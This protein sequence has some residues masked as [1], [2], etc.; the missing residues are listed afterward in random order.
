MSIL[1]YITL[2]LLIKLSIA[3]DPLLG[4]FCTLLSFVEPQFSA[5][6]HVGNNMISLNRGWLKSDFKVVLLPKNTCQWIQ[7]C[8]DSQE[9]L[10][11]CQLNTERLWYDYSEKIVRK[12]PNVQ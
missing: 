5:I 11:I 8:P 9:D 12:L 2:L 10:E 6:C 4:T 7:V 3:A 1:Y